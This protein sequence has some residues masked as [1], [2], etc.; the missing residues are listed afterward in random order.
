MITFDWGKLA[1][2]TT[3]K[4]VEIPGGKEI[5]L[6]ATWVKQI[7]RTGRV[8]QAPSFDPKPTSVVEPEEGRVAVQLKKTQ[9]QI[10]VWGQ[11]LA[12]R[13]H[14]TALMKILDES[15]IPLDPTLAQLTNMVVTL[16]AQQSLAFSD[17]YLS[18]LG[19]NHNQALHAMIEAL[20]MSI[21]YVLVDNGSTIN[22]CSLKTA[23]CL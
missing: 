23:T 9:A 16:G 11:L 19:R 21:P 2:S 17:E 22:V 6:V 7:T 12:S 15:T 20:G 10:Y 3:S 4:E 14:R 8:Y 13:P 18:Q 5:N 1:S